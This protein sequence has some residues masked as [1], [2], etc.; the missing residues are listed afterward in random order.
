MSLRAFATNQANFKKGQNFLGISPGPASL[1]NYSLFHQY[2]KETFGNEPIANMMLTVS[3]MDEYNN[4]D[5]QSFL[6]I[7]EDEGIPLDEGFMTT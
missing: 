2:D 5:L 7:N 6:E 4:W 1:S 3:Q